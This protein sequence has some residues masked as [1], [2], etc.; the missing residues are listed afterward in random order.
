MKTLLLICFCMCFG[1]AKAQNGVVVENAPMILKTYVYHIPGDIDSL[2]AADINDYFQNRKAF[3]GCEV[4]FLLDTVRLKVDSRLSDKELDRFVLLIVADIYY[5]HRHT[6]LA[7][8]SEHKC[9]G[10][11]TNNN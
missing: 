4:D 8:S 9:D 2:I 3:Y 10:A 5:K 6:C 7:H 1:L 11:H